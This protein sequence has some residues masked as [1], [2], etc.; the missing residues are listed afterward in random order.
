MKLSDF[1]ALWREFMSASFRA[2][3]VLTVA[4]LFFLFGRVAAVAGSALAVRSAIDASLAGE[5]VEAA[6]AACL[7]AISY[8]VL[9]VSQDIA[10]SLIL[11]VADRA[12]RMELNPRSNQDLATIEGIAHLESA[13]VRDRVTLT[14]KSGGR[15]AAGMW[16]ALK[17]LASVSSLLVIIVILS[18]VSPLL[19]LLVVFA[20]LPIW[21]DNLGNSIVARADVESAETYRLQ[22]HLFD[23]LTSASSIKEIK[24][25]GSADT[26]IDMQGRAWEEAMRIRSRARL[27]AE[28]VGLIGWAL[29]VSAF[30]GGLLVASHRAIEGVSTAGDI[31]MIV[32]LAASLRSSV[33]ATVESTSDAISARQYL[34]PFRWLRG[35]VQSERT[36]S[37][38]HQLTP[39]RLDEGIVLD[40]V[41]FRYPGNS[42]F[43]LR[44]ISMRI[45]AGSTLAVVGEYGSGKSTLVKLLCKFYEPTTGMIRV[46]GT[47]L[48]ELETQ[49]WRDRITATFQDYA[50][51]GATVR[52]NVGLGRVAD[53]NNSERI[54]GAVA[55]AGADALIVKLRDGLDTQLGTHLGGVDLSEGQ[56]QRLALARGFVREQPLLLLLDEPTASLDAPTERSIFNQYMARAKRLAKEVGA[57]CIVISHRFATVQ[58]ADQI[59]V[60]KDGML[61]EAGSHEELVASGGLYEELYSIS[62]R[63]YS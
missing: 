50:R 63:G 26:I 25:S 46:D 37:V 9:I 2:A 53:L 6:V 3:P 23:V 15:L 30:V 32:T 38:G 31:V 35:F 34:E 33:Q 61:I 59:A 57:I 12:G 45:P 48:H 40:R 21:F 19:L 10:D 36:R 55:E 39:D 42:E 60:F 47:P 62:V 28:A 54:N 56:W 20:A 43:A 29:F 51:F 11:T 18:S 49:G 14:H 52:V 27:Q 44:E 8:A 4:A 22:T 1:F 5:G 24:M 7:A 17:T 16:Q 13:D 41:S 58:G